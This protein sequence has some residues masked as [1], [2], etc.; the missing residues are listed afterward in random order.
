MI[1]DVTIGHYLNSQCNIP[2]INSELL[3]IDRINTC[4]ENF[5]HFAITY[6]KNQKIPNYRVKTNN[7]DLVDIFVYKFLLKHIY[8][9]S[10]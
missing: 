7:R 1:E 4:D 8:N 9:I 6:S 5:L 3:F 2:I 10:Y